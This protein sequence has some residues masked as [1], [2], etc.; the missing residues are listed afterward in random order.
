MPP[1][2]HSTQLGPQPLLLALMAL[3]VVSLPA[4]GEGPATRPVKVTVTFDRSLGP[5]EIDRVAS[6]GQGGLSE[7][8]MWE[9]RAAE[10][11]ALRPRVIRLF[12]QEY[13][14]VMPEKGRYDFGKIDAVVDLVQRCG[15]EPLMCI[16]FKPKALFPRIDPA[17]V[18]PEDWDEWG[19]LIEAMV[20]R[21]KDRGK[22]RDGAGP[23]VRY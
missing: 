1:P 13:F 5:L 17:A 2:D 23:V 20:R 6:L 4:Q 9:G 10:V 21:Y 14:D 19:R 22:G 3:L 16:A 11:R 15:A 8:P 7:E 18:E 12:L